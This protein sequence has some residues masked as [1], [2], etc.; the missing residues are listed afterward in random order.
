MSS[1]LALLCN[2]RSFVT[3][4]SYSYQYLHGVYPEVSHI[5]FM[6]CVHYCPVLEMISKLTLELWYL[7]LYSYVFSS[8]MSIHPKGGG[9]ALNTRVSLINVDMVSGLIKCCWLSPFS[10]VCRGSL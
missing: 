3:D 6:I 7:F 5:Y 1:S 10:T 8:M 2:S 9:S 4:L